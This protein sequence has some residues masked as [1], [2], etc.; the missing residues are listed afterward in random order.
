VTLQNL[1]TIVRQLLPQNIILHAILIVSP[2]SVLLFGDIKAKIFFWL[3]VLS[4]GLE[5]LYLKFFSGF[6]FR[7]EQHLEFYLILLS[8]LFCVIN[9]K[10][11]ILKTL[12]LMIISILITSCGLLYFFNLAEMYTSEHLPAE[13]VRFAL[14]RIN[15]YDWVKIRFPSVSGVGIWCGNSGGGPVALARFDPDT[16][17]FDANGLIRAYFVRCYYKNPD[18]SPSDWAKLPVVAKEKKL[19]FWTFTTNPC[20]PEERVKNKDETADS[21]MDAKSLADMLQLRRLNN[22]IVCNSE[23]VVPNLYYFDYEELK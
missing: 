21:S 20:I 18:L 14:S 22:A 9:F 12:K 16:I 3:L 19:K 4:F 17:W 6:L 5:L 13:E 10:N 11:K 1:Y 7:Y 8:V 23:T 2:M 15:I